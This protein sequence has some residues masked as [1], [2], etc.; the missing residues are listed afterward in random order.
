MNRTATNIIELLTPETKKNLLKAIGTGRVSL[1]ELREPKLRK[2]LPTILSG[3]VPVVAKFEGSNEWTF[4]TY[5]GCVIETEQDFDLIAKIYDAIHNRT[6]GA[7]VIVRANLGIPLA[8][9]ESE[10]KE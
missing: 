3:C 6:G 5:A 9:S 2:Y 10:I 8:S 1:A 7:K 4:P